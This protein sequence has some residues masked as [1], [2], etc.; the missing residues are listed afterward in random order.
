MMPNSF[1]H[2][3]FL[4]V[5]IMLAPVSNAFSEDVSPEVIESDISFDYVQA[6]FALTTVNPGDSVSEADGTGFGFSLSLEINKYSAFT[7][8]VISTTFDTFQGI[9]VES[10]KLTTYGFTAHTLIAPSTEVYA[11]LSLA[12]ANASVPEDS[13]ASGGEDYGG[14][15]GV[16]LRYLV[17][18][19]IELEIAG[20]NTEVF[21]TSVFSYNLETRIYFRKVY[22]LGVG[23]VS[24]DNADSFQF[25]IRMDI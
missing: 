1:I 5:L 10:A 23:Y 3:T 13:T 24:S 6:T 7:L 20:S 14:V 19:K 15:L 9:E 16:G 25:H 12:I 11:N 17:T 22:S 18:D 8:S 21:D 2:R 4:T